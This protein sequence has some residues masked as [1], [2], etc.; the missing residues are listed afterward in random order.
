[1]TMNVATVMELPGAGDDDAMA[2]S[3]P[4]DIPP[5]TGTVRRIG[6]AQNLGLA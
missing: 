3:A 6:L 4:E 1:M 2:R 5:A